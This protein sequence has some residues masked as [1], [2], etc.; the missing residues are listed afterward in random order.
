MLLIAIFDVCDYDRDAG[1][2]EYSAVL[3][4]MLR[5]WE[6]LWKELQ[7]CSAGIQEWNEVQGDFF[8]AEIKTC[9]RANRSC[10]SMKSFIWES[11]WLA[12]SPF[13]ILV[14]NKGGSSLKSHPVSNLN[15]STLNADALLT[16]G[17]KPL[18]L[19][20]STRAGD[21][22]RQRAAQ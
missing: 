9:Q 19:V 2:I 14:L 17:C 6:T 21:A 20:F 3:S 11:L 13:F 12:R 8:S 7:D 5:S 18:K 15:I 1:E 10:C 4:A 22:K 16:F